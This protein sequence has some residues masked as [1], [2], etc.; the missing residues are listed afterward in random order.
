[1]TGD[2]PRCG[3]LSSLPTRSQYRASSRTPP[4][5]QQSFISLH[6]VGS[7]TSP[8]KP[9]TAYA[10]VAGQIPKFFS[11]FG[12]SRR[13]CGRWRG[14]IRTWVFPGMNSVAISC[15]SGGT[16]VSE[17][18]TLSVLILSFEHTRIL[19]ETMPARTSSQPEEGFIIVNRHFDELQAGY[20]F[21]AAVASASCAIS[22]RGRCN[23]CW[24]PGA[25]PR[26]PMAATDMRCSTCRRRHSC[27]C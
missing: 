10:G 22:Q 15:F 14:T 18:M 11:S 23:C 3:S 7:Q 9:K 17:N 27:C 25:L 16:R 6:E 12:Y 1:M 4:G 26:L 21:V 13:R 24:R 20:G 2:G 8:V 5:P 19:S